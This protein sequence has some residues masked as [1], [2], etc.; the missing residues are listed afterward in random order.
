MLSSVR[1]RGP[2]SESRNAREDRV[3][4]LRPDEGL[5]VGLM[6]LDKLE[7]RGLELR[8]AAERAAAELFVRELGKPALHEA[9]PG[10]VRRGEVHV[11]PRPLREP[12]TN[13]RGFVGAVVVHDDVHVQGPRDLGLDQI[14]EFTELR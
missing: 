12:I 9:Q 7:N 1:V 13:Q 14:E 10:A 6:G 8:H 5:R 2:L 11:E 4:A 3:R